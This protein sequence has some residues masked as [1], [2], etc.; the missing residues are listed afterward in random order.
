MLFEM[1]FSMLALP[2]RA[3]FLSLRHVYKCRNMLYIIVI[4]GYLNV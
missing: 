3:T 1:G 4:I 2:N